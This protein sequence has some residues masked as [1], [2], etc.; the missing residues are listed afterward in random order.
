[1]LRHKLLLL[2][3]SFFVMQVRAAPG[4][5]ISIDSCYARSAIHYPLSKQYRML[6][7]S[8]NWQL[9]QAAKGYLPQLLLAGQATHQSA[10]TQL[11]VDIPNLHIP[12]LDKTQYRVYGE[13]SQSLTGFH[14]VGTQRDLIRDNTE[15]E[16]QKNRVELYKVKDRVNNL[17]FGVLLTDAQL[18]QNALYKQDILAG[19]DKANTAFEAGTILKSDV[20]Q[21]K[22]ELLKAD[23][24]NTE[25]RANR[26]A[27]LGMLS[28]LTGLVLDTDTRLIVPAAPATTATEITRP[29]LKLYELQHAY[30]RRQEQSV[31][32]KLLPNL[33]LFLQSGLGRPGLNMLD[34]Q[35]KAY[36]IGGVRLNW[37][38][39][40]YYTA[41]KEKKLL[42]L[43]R[44]M[45]EVQKETF[46]MN[47]RISRQQYNA[48]IM[49]LEQMLAGDEQIIALREDILVQFK[50]QLTYGTTT[51]TDYITQANAADQARQLYQLHNLQLTLAKYNYK[52]ISGE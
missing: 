2:C 10:V 29:E 12:T 7:Q 25:L 41:G 13:V 8:G 45:T 46:L 26:V 1:M 43:N 33:S 9:D 40:N 27:Y 3:A 15:M 50:A 20:D 22:V 6:T 19:L 11:P 39:S 31:N 16:L 47:T 23:Q 52:N 38:F 5:V 49:K 48:E 37:T 14:T 36:Y 18:A 44:D 34:N 35:T 4:A 28:E 24:K 51:V 32:D 42:R 17:Y 30:L 21:L